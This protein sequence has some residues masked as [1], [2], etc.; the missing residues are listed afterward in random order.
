M[1][2][3]RTTLELLDCHVTISI[4]CNAASI[5][6]V[7]FWVPRSSTRQQNV[8]GGINTWTVASF[9]SSAPERVCIIRWILDI[10]ILPCESIHSAMDIDSIFTSSQTEDVFEMNVLVRLPVTCHA[11]P[12]H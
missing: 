1:I 4:G 10:E 3:M 6:S 11:A 5:T 7:I 12:K 2:V 9:G 8:G